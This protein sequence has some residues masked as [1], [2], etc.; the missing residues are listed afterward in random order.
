MN[1]DR[2]S[3]FLWQD[4]ELTIGGPIPG[5]SKKDLARLV[6]VRDFLWRAVS[7][8]VVG[9]LASIFVIPVLVGVGYA[10][11]IFI[12]VVFLGASQCPATSCQ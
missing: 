2:L 10:A 1:D 7:L 3:I 11:W 4:S 8:L 5:P 6:Q 9:I 12:S